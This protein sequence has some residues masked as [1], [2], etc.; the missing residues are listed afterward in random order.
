MFHSL[1]IFDHALIGFISRYCYVL[2]MPLIFAAAK[3]LSYQPPDMFELAVFACNKL[4]PYAMMPVEYNFH[5]RVNDEQKKEKKTEWGNHHG[6][7]R[8]QWWR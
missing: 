1:L 8:T 3:R 2:I 4:P 5:T 6:A 7:N